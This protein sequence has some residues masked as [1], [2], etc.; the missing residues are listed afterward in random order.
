MTNR[1][2]VLHMS[3]AG[4]TDLSRE[5]DQEMLG[6]W[7]DEGASAGRL[8]DGG[9]VA[10][11]EEA[12]SVAVREGRVVVTDGPFPEFKEWFAGYD[13]IT[14]DSLEDAAAFMAGHPLATQGR[15]YILPMVTLPWDND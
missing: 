10:A 8:H 11:P 5:E 1:Y 7:A 4:G 2:L 9:P 12:R 3:D 14:A 15:V 6:R 13:L